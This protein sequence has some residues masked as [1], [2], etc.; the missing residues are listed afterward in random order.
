MR[1]I[2][3][4]IAATLLLVLSA[5]G[6][7][8]DHPEA[9]A[10]LELYAPTLAGGAARTHFV[11]HGTIPIPKGIFPRPDHKSPFSV[12]NH[13]PAAT[14]VP[15][16]VEIV[17]RYPTGEAD[18]VEV[19]APVD[20]APEDH[21]GNPVSYSIVASENKLAR[22]PTVTPRVANL[23]SRLRHGNFG[24]RARDVYGNVYWADLSGNPS[25]PGFGSLRV[26]K[27]GPW[28]PPEPVSIA[29]LS[30]TTCIGRSEDCER[31]SGRQVRCRMA[32]P[33]CPSRSCSS[34][35]R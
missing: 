33:V 6:Q 13:D 21:P 35:I 29:T 14:L 1:T 27:S 23:L 3:G 26:L 9:L 8:L 12:M 31:R 30:R 15:A 17:S 4:A 25:D 22:A 10:R 5:P 16:Q 32:H 7:E 2:L 24:L 18:V 20:L 28:M 11:L 34:T 19:F